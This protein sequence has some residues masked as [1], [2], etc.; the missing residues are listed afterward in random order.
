[1][2]NVKGLVLEKQEVSAW[3]AA[4]KLL[5]DNSVAFPTGIKHDLLGGI[6]VSFSI[7]HASFSSTLHI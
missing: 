6:D 3:K 7:Y 1:M 2:E 5:R 4:L